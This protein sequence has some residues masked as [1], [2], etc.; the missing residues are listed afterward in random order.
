MTIETSPG[1]SVYLDSVQEG[2]V[3]Y[4]SN[5][6]L[7]GLTLTAGIGGLLF[8]YD[9]D[10]WTGTRKLLAFLWRISQGIYILKQIYNF[11]FPSSDNRKNINY[12]KFEISPRGLIACVALWGTEY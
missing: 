5:R 4:F 12:W 7:L 6:Y 9:T 8:G 10:P 1:N 11:P 3:S 2:K